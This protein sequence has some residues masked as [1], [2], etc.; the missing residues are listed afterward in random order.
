MAEKY[1]KTDR[2]WAINALRE[3]EL[4]ADSLPYT[5]EF[6][7]LFK[8]F[9]G[10]QLVAWTRPD[11]WKLL[12]TVRK[13]GL[14]RQARVKVESPE[15]SLKQIARLRELMPEKRGE[16]DRLPYTSRFD[17][18]YAEFKK[19]VAG[20]ITKREV[21]LACLKIVK[22]RVRPKAK[23]FLDKAILR[24]RSAINAFREVLSAPW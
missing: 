13:R 7:A 17:S 20:Q 12:L 8:E 16:V 19:F 3:S 22:S 24:L 18:I 23:P 11:F 15:L 14:G 9:N 6:E 1:A 2:D 5:Q 21:W 4:A 10:S